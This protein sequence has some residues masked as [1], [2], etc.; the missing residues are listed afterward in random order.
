MPK[1]L[2]PNTIARIEKDVRAENRETASAIAARLGV[3]VSS[4][5]RRAR[6]AG[7][8]YYG[9][10]R[11]DEDLAVVA[12]D[13]RAGLPRGETASLLGLSTKAI[14]RRRGELRR[15]RRLPRAPNAPGKGAR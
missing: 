11:T 10:R 1:L 5:A 2:A 8:P 13:A 4:V 6:A 9:R 7:R 14:A 15:R 12:E 3:A